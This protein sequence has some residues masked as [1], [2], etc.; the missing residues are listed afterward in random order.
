MRGRSLI[1][2][3]ARIS[4][5]HYTRGGINLEPTTRIIRQAV[6]DSIRGTVRIGGARLNTNRR[7][8][9]CVFRD[10]IRGRV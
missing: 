4:N 1:I 10:L 5:R 2:Q 8:I 6:G 9:G 7:P 3:L